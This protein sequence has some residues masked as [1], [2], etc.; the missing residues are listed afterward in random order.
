MR[1]AV[2]WDASHVGTGFNVCARRRQRAH[3]AKRTNAHRFA[4]HACSED[5]HSSV[6]CVC[7]CDV[8]QIPCAKYAH[9]S[10]VRRARV[11]E[12]CA[13][14]GVGMD[15]VGTVHQVVPVHSVTAAA[16]CSERRRYAMA[17]AL[18]TCSKRG[19]RWSLS[20]SRDTD[21]CSRSDQWKHT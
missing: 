13:Y 2:P 21:I 20:T 6:N 16:G 8:E 4:A 17:C 1:G 14:K 5:A 12:C 19:K 3:V 11:R 10:R 15:S 18:V 7:K 9:G